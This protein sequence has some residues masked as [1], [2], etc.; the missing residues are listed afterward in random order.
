VFNNLKKNKE[1]Y[2]NKRGG[3][4][5]PIFCNISPQTYDA[6]ALSI[7]SL[8][9]RK[10]KW[11]I[12]YDLIKKFAIYQEKETKGKVMVSCLRWWQLRWQS[13]STCLVCSWKTELWAIWIELWL[14]QYIGVR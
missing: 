12:E 1:K 3:G 13:I 9:T 11:K 8:P 14:S 4:Y 5:N 7:E 6:T 10:Q 2:K